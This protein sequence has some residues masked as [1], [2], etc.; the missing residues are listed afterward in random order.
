MLLTP[1]LAY[2][3]EFLGSGL[4]QQGPASA[5]FRTDEF[6]ALGGFPDVAYAGDYLFW[7]R[8]CAVVNGGLWCW[9]QGY[10]G[11]LGNGSTAD[12]SVPVQVSGLSSGVQAVASAALISGTLGRRNTATSRTFRSNNRSDRLGLITTTG[13]PLA[14]YSNSFVLSRY[15]SLRNASRY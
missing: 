11:G 13:L 5:L 14:K 10:A 6:R 2:E 15:D 9:G 8:A 1:R 12:S 4:F 7:L 3:R